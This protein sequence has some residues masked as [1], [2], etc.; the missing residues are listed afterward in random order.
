MRTLVEEER[1]KT[2]D[3]FGRMQERC[4]V[5]RT[6]GRGVR[7]WAE[8][9]G[10]ICYT[11]LAGCRFQAQ[12]RQRFHRLSYRTASPEI[13]HHRN[14]LPAV[15][16]GTKIAALAELQLHL[17]RLPDLRVGNPS[18]DMGKVLGR[19]ASTPLAPPAVQLRGLR[20]CSSH[21]FLRQ[22]LQRVPLEL[23]CVFSRDR[24]SRDHRCTRAK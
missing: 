21:R 18:A 2:C 19:I 15:G 7:S 14:L 9:D 17:K 5:H 23:G 16:K 8:P 24:R 13:Q 3:N 11:P 20:S 22:R 6:H 4:P 12:C 10:I 1:A